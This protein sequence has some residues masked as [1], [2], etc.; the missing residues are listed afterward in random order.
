MGARRL[1][2]LLTGN[3][4]EAEDLVQDAFVRVAVRLADLRDPSRFPSYLNRTL[5][6]MAASRH[7]RRKTEKVALQRSVSLERQAYASADSDGHLWLTLQTLPARQR[8]AIVLRFYQDLTEDQISEAM[9]C[10]RG[11]VKSLIF[12]GLRSMRTS[13]GS[14]TD[15]ITAASGS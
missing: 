9:N 10:P 11:T 8:A 5:V 13:L 1:A 2:Y 14:D 6:T 12:R 4:A 15:E 3:H 7:R